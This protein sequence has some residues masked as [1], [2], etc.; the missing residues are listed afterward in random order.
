MV[1]GSALVLVRHGYTLRWWWRRSKVGKEQ[2]AHA[3]ERRRRSVASA[4]A[5]PAKGS[6]K[7]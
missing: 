6:D 1:I 2:E 7:G 4:T 5:T 3:A